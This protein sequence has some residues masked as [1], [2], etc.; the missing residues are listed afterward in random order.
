MFKG[1][2]PAFLTLDFH[3]YKFSFRRLQH[4]AIAISALS[5]VYNGAEAGLSM[6]FGAES[7][8]SLIFFGIQSGIEV[9]SSALVLW[10]FGKVAKP[11]DE[12]GVTLRP[13]ELKYVC[14]HVCS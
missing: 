6:G 8:R 9:I 2:A 14:T 1:R 12:R 5:V 3:S 11:G 13:E 4:F 7:S 10:R